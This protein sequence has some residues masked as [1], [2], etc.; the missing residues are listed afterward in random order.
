MLF[1]FACSPLSRSLQKNSGAR[2]GPVVNFRNHRGSKLGRAL[3][4]EERI[5][6]VEGT[7]CSIAGLRP[8]K[9]TAAQIERS[10]ALGL[11]STVVI[12]SKMSVARAS[13]R[14]TGQAG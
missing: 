5:S 2:V 6:R 8:S 3:R 11:S 4:K 10:A 13:A 12:L 14:Y 7:L 1:S 9:G